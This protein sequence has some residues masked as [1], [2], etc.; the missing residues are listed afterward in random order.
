MKKLFTLAAAVLAS[1]TMWANQTDLISGV[2]LP[3]MPSA[4]L[5]LT[6]QTTFT[7]D[8]NGWIVFDPYASAANLSTIPAWWKH[9]NKSG[10]S[11]N[12][13]ESHLTA[14]DPTAPFFAKTTTNVKINGGSTAYAAAIR[15][16]GAE[17][18]SFLVHP[19]SSSNNKE[20]NVA[21]FSYNSGATP[22]QTQ[23]GST[24]QAKTNAFNELLF[25]DLST[26]NTY[27]AYVW[28]GSGGQNGALCE[29]AIKKYV[30]TVV[31]PVAEVTLD[32]P[33]T[34]SIGYPATY[35]AT[36][37]VKADAYKWFVNDVEQEGATTKTF[38]LTPTA[39]TTYSIVCKARNAFNV[40]DEWIA[41]AAKV[42]KAYTLHGEL[43]KATLT[44]GSAAT[45]TGTVGGTAD[46]SLSSN[47]KLDKNKHFGIAL[48]SGTFHEGDTVVITMTTAGSN[49]PCIFA[50]KERTNCLYLA[51][52]TSS[53]LEYKIVLTDAANSINTI[54]VSRGDESDGYKWNPVLSSMAVVRP[55][56]AKSTVETL[57]GVTI[58]DEA[59]SAANLAKLQT[60][61]EIIL[62]DSYI[63]APVVK[64]TKHVVTTYEDDSQ[65]EIDEVIEK[66][67]T[68]ASAGVWGASATIGGNAYA[69]YTVIQSSYVVT[70]K[71]GA[72]TLGTENVAP[73]S[74]PV[75]Y[76]QY[77]SKQ[78][79]S[80]V[81]W[82]SDAA[83]ENAV[84][85]GEA[86]IT[87]DTTFYAKFENAYATSVNFEKIVMQ[88]G[89][90]YAIISQLGTQHYAS[91]ITGSLDSLDNSKSDKL[92]NYAYLGLKVKQSGALLNF[93]LAAGKTVKIKFGDIKTANPHLSVNEGAYAEMTITDKVFSYTAEA[94]ALL[95]IKTVNGDAVVFQQIAIGE[96]LAAPELF[97]ITCET[98]DNGTF[99]TP[100]KLGIPNENVVITA[101][102]ADGYKTA[103]VL[104][105]GTRLTLGEEISFDMPAENVTI[106]GEFTV[107][108][109]PT[110]LDNTE[111]NAKAVKMIEN[112]QIVIIKNGVRYNVLGAELR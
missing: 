24:K 62:E 104:V 2:T 84:T 66:T 110:A 90:G 68:V 57:T 26:S 78:L 54:Y 111:D 45:V 13:E 22:S 96:E 47:L 43:I 39:A 71:D 102:P 29:I 95:S 10:Q 59:I 101:T 27:V 60:T 5:D 91:N 103:L 67:S 35:T 46:V 81:A 25:E 28:G 49:Y 41:S 56:A 51:T 88:N 42:V 36:T 34:A 64:F 53:A 74:N 18:I 4:S 106:T 7:P 99:A 17:T 97:S 61:G 21:I 38:T 100:Y 11:Q 92:R 80:F 73:Y 6:S 37:D 50:D 20:M 76:A 30:A 77:Q 93:R 83:L 52:E 86:V 33:S 55:M 79:S 9:T 87:K 89:K 15:F 8:D 109:Y 19:R 58:N 12:F 63:D 16:T 75:E 3:D 32:G 94:D 98:V 72:E 112:G 105:N 108:G 65:K 14:L 70:Y 40:T 44:S 85:I 48:K 69:V 31:D 23:V 107:S 82:Y 1:L